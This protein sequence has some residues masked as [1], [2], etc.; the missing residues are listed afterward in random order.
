MDAELLKNI[1]LSVQR[2]TAVLLWSLFDKNSDV[3]SFKTIGKFVCAVINAGG[4]TYAEKL[5][6]EKQQNFLDTLNEVY[7]STPFSQLT[8]YRN[9]E[10]AHSAISANERVR[11]QDQTG[12]L[13]SPIVIDDF[14][15][16]LEKAQL[17]DDQSS[18]VL[19]GKLAGYSSME[20]SYTTWMPTLFEPFE[21]RLKDVSQK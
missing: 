16:L 9:E 18:I 6:L 8:I 19:G 11:K 4:D 13:F 20:M 2:D 3:R 12:N 1:G 14:E 15:Y 7:G 17:L 21:K 10:A 5:A